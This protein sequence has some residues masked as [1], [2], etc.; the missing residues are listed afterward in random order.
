MFISRPDAQLYAVAFGPG[1]QVLVALGG[2]VGSWEVW[3]EP[4]RLLS[5]TWR[6]IAYDH[7]G[8]GATI[9]PVESITTNSVSPAI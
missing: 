7:R 2:W 6:T 4:F 9:A 3:A 8:A 1:S 5:S